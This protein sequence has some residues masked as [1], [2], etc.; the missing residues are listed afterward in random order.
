MS[1]EVIEKA[2]QY[3]Y[4][5]VTEI[6][7]GKYFETFGQHPVLATDANE[8]AF[9]LQIH[10]LEKAIYELGYEFNGR[11]TWVKIPLKGIEQVMKEMMTV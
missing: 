8:K 7:L 5:S 11:P 9:L 2:A 4:E 1:D 3:W 10:L 6:Y